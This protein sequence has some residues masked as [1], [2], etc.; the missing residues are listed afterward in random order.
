MIGL[1]IGGSF[2]PIFIE[3]LGADLLAYA[4]SAITVSASMAAMILPMSFAASRWPSMP[5]AQSVLPGGLFEFKNRQLRL[6]LFANMLQ[7]A[8]LATCF[9]ALPYLVD[10]GSRAPQLGLLI[11]IVV[12]TAATSIGIWNKTAGRF[13]LTLC[14]A[15][16]G[17]VF[18]AGTASLGIAHLV[19]PE[20]AYF[21]GAVLC[22]AGLGAIQFAAY[23][24]LA[25]CLQKLIEQEPAFPAASVVG[26]W[27][28][29]ERATLALGPL[30]V[31][32]LLDLAGNRAAMAV[33]TISI[34]TTV[35]VLSLFPLCIFPKFGTPHQQSN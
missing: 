34:T 33:S 29:F 21:L 4:I 11:A 17:I 30:M 23:A 26:F 24:L 19:K 5:P 3:Y 27:T 15:L 2:A 18:A 6:L 32:V 28:A 22:G 8:A 16:G 35:V 10:E 1:L 31:G 9:T 25:Q 7:V 20:G 13:G 12:I 14:F